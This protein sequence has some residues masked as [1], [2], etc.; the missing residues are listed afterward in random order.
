MQKSRKTLLMAASLF[1]VAAALSPLPA[2]GSHLCGAT[3]TA[4]T[5]LD[6]NQVCTGNGVTIGADFVRLKLNG[7]SIE[8]PLDVI[9]GAPG[10]RCNAFTG[11]AT[12]TG[13][14][15]TGRT[16]VEITGP[17]SVKRFGTGI[18][19][20]GGTNNSIEAGILGP[21]HVT[22]NVDGV[23]LDGS[24]TANTIQE[25]VISLNCGIGVFLDSAHNNK[26]EDNFCDK[27]HGPPTCGC[28][29]AVVS[30][31]N[32]VQ[33]NTMDQNGDFA[34]DFVT[35]NGNKVQDNIATNSNFFGFPTPGIE[36]SSSNGNKVE[37]NHSTTNSHGILLIN[38]TS[39]ALEANTALGNSAFDLAEF[40][41]PSPP[42]PNTWEANTFVTT[43]DTPPMC[44]E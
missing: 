35:S 3:I 44:I 39:N 33:R 4:N 37:R 31:N 38:S 28:L 42:C 11:D 7:F 24:T 13:V 16:G 23:R 12:T 29:Q 40:P 30:N 6:H 14:I 9:F 18:L 8:G 43:N 21:V 5:T 19:I 17:G 36:F 26:I 10:G 41:D 2:E 27:N 15:V 20:S 34:I 1:L 22:E 32:K 25:N